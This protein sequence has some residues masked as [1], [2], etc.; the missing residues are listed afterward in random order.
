MA[1]HS[2]YCLVSVG[3]ELDVV[4]CTHGFTFLGLVIYF[5]CAKRLRCQALVK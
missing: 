5:H 3:N 1:L 4:D 2:A